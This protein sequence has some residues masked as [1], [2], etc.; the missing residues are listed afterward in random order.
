[1]EEFLKPFLQKLIELIDKGQYWTVSFYIL[2]IIAVCVGLGYIISWWLNQRKIQS[3]IQ[4]LNIEV[5]EKKLSILKQVQVARRDYINKGQYAQL[6][7]K[8]MIEAFVSNDRQKIK[9]TR[10]Q[11]ID[12]YFNELLTSYENYLEITEV[13]FE[14]DKKKILT[15]IKDEVFELFKTTL[16]ML[17]TINSQPVLSAT[18][19][20][21]Y[22]LNKTT[23]RPSFRYIDENTGLL[24]IR[25]T[26]VKY[27]Y[28]YKFYY[29]KDR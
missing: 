1:M 6:A 26:V 10:D 24:N 20:Q 4:K 27:I 25:V 14:A 16:L 28:I 18:G 19:D 17:N 8:E 9:K 11:L 2:G 22:I 7:T 21:K 23:L 29:R 13:Y 3:E 5:K 12:F 15:F